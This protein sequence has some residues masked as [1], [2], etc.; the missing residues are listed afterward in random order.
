M[1]AVA[2]YDRGVIDLTTL[3]ERVKA[4]RSAGASI[5]F[6][7]GCF[8]LLHIGH[9]ALLQA[10]AAQGDRLIVAV[11][12][13][14]SVGR[15]KGPD[16]PLTP[17][18]ERA[19]LLAGL[20]RRRLGSRVLGSH[21]AGLDRS[22]R[23][24]RPRQGWRLA[25]R[26]VRRRGTGAGSRGPRRSRA[27]SFGTLHDH[28]AAEDSRQRV[29]NL[30]QPLVEAPFFEELSRRLQS[31]GKHAV[32]S[33]LVESSRALTL[34]LLA[35]RQ[36]K[37]LLLVTADDTKLESHRGDFA[38]FAEL[39]GLSPL[40]IATLPALDADP[41]DGIPPHSEVVR[42]RVLALGRLHRRELD[43]LL[44]PV[45]S[46]LQPIAPPACWK[47]WIR[48][49]RVGDTLTPDRFVRDTMALGYQR[50]DIVSAPGEVSRRG[51]IIDLYPPECGE[52]RRIELF[53]DE[54]ES[55]RGFD[56]DN[57][58]STGTLHEVRAGPASEKPAGR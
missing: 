27:T 18:A 31:S 36:R 34:L 16:R 5:V 6:T 29:M 12:D 21:T 22:D 24:R 2:C 17:W 15:L 7:N 42:E 23:T 35:R 44:T 9:L 30:W 52:P 58:R 57:Q 45:R 32:V 43:V 26:P 38:T 4:D 47:E 10:A 46:L 54:V 37:P 56:T 40:R 14:P 25:H 19:E 41:Y 33:G 39:L 3:L 51:G 50:V 13:D 53:G 55:I 28:I 48:T 49:I 8:D 20:G 1:R 11:N